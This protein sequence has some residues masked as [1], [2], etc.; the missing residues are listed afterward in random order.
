MREITNFGG[1]LMMR[2][3]KNLFFMVLVV[4]LAAL[5]ME[6]D[7][8]NPGHQTRL[9]SP[10][11]PQPDKI[12]LGRQLVDAAENAFW[13]AIGNAK[14]AEVECLIDLGPDLGQ[15]HSNGWNALMYAAMS[16]REEIVQRLITAGADLN[17]QSKN[18][19]TALVHAV[20]WRSW[21]IC[22]MLI[23]AMLDHNSEQKTRIYTTLLCIKQI[24]CFTRNLTRDLFKPVLLPTLTDVRQEINRIT[25]EEIRNQLLEKY[26]FQP[27]TNSEAK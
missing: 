24:H 27:T 8:T 23:D 16:N 9:A 3:L 10:D 5:A 19:M 18:G 17:L 11:A 2:L 15:E 13:D 1:S 14:W 4:P 20:N 26:G 12:E 7:Y 25:N 21:P 22:P 6:S